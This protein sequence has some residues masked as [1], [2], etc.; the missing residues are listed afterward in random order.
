MTAEPQNHSSKIHLSLNDRILKLE[1]GFNEIK[2]KLTASL[3]QSDIL[4]NAVVD[5]ANKISEI[6]NILSERK[7]SSGHSQ[8]YMQPLAEKVA[9]LTPHSNRMAEELENSKIE[10]EPLEHNSEKINSLSTEEKSPSNFK[11]PKIEISEEGIKVIEMGDRDFTKDFGISIPPLREK[12]FPQKK[13][14]GRKKLLFSISLVAIFTTVSLFAWY[15][16][17]TPKQQP[18]EGIIAQNIKSPTTQRSAQ[19]ILP[20]PSKIAPLPKSKFMKQELKPAEP[21]KKISQRNKFIP[22]PQT[23]TKKLPTP[24]DKSPA[25]RYPVLKAGAYT[26]N[27]G[28]FKKKKRALDFAKKLQ[29]KGYPSLISTAKKKKMYRV[30][31]GAFSTYNEAKYYNTTLQKKEQLTTFISKIN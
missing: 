2:S 13:G 11:I 17:S 1:N 15:Y 7:Q 26:I 19:G 16:F 8:E 23:I 29:D 10:T 4:K 21:N 9:N 12:I 31:V 14:K 18:P 30:R 27:V 24:T 20:P 5:L 22:T 25:Q 3:N 6:S 28:S